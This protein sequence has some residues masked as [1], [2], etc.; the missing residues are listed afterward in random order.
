VD[1]PRPELPP[2]RHLQALAQRLGVDGP[3]AELTFDNGS[4]VLVERRLVVVGR[5]AGVTRFLLE[6]YDGGELH[7]MPAELQRAYEMAAGG[8]YRYVKQPK[9]DPSAYGDDAPF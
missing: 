9:G 3:P 7:R 2:L 6:Q 8:S 5:W 1:S 4:R